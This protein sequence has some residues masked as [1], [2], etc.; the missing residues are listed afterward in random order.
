MSV[1]QMVRAS[2]RLPK[3]GNDFEYY[4]TFPG[5]QHFTKYQKSKILSMIDTLL[6]NQGIKDNFCVERKSTLNEAEDLTDSL[7]SCN[8][9]F[10]ER[11]NAM[12][13]QVQAKAKKNGSH[14]ENIEETPLGKPHVAATTNNILPAPKTV[15]SS[16]NKVDKHGRSKSFR[17]I[18]AYNIMRPQLKFKDKI[19]NSSAPFVP[20]LITKPNALKPLPD[21][22]IN[23]HQ[24]GQQK[25]GPSDASVALTN[26]IQSVRND[27][28][29]DSSIY[30]HPYQYE[31]EQYQVSEEQVAPT[32]P[33]KAGV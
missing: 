7:V 9:L 28:E 8:D 14:V 13:D 27:K 25:V 18:Q 24:K 30:L 21:A 23:L 26:L 5:F 6:K 12:M 11:I 16:W 2:H 31:I 4:E 15:V 10:I 20:K 33:I 3:V 22:L 1:I 32:E 29:E 19:D 17:L